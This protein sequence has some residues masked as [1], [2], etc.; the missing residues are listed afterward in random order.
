VSNQRKIPRLLIAGLS[1]G[2]G[3]TIVSLG[4]LQLLRRAGYRVRAFKKGPDYIDPAWL[5]WASGHPARNLDTY[6]MGPSGVRASFQRHAVSD[7]INLIEGNRGLFDGFDVSG[8]HS[9]AVLAKTLDAPILLVID[10]AKMTRTAAALVLGCQK[11]DPHAS[12]RGVVLNNVNGERH[13]KILRSA[14]EAECGIPVVGVL[15]RAANNPLP[16]R[17]L[18]LVPP[19]ECGE[20][21]LIERSLLK[22]VERH[23]DL[24]AV[25]AIAGCAA[26]LEE[27]EGTS[28]ALPDGRGLKIGYLRDSAFSFYYPE[29]LEEL[30]RAGAE[31]VRISALEAPALPD[32][33]H[34]LYIGGGF[35]ETHASE[36]ASNL[37]FL[38]SIRDACASGLPVYAECGGLML[39]ARSLN[40]NG[41]RY[42]M[43]N[44]FPVDVEVFRSPQG[45]GYSQL[46]VD[47]NNPFFPRG[48]KLRGHEFHYSRI[49]SDSSAAVTACSIGRGVGCFAGRDFLI[50]RNAMAGYTHLHA[51]ATPEWAAGM[52]NAAR[53]FAVECEPGRS[54]TIEGTNGP[55]I[56]LR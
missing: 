31:L 30:E 35:P 25:A 18:G 7:G 32:D 33:L 29:N 20:I 13:E 15:P 50:A 6:L 46:H 56:Q 12:I 43:A 48:A 4:L 10:A 52:V 49:V 28:A 3:K 19:E 8:S 41:A 37:C 1:G 11:L 44:V 47:T 5:A 51:T 27:N 17:H 54:T 55:A 2:S 9:S 23:F 53:K 21:D 22:L 34:A 42:P 14:I 38:E 36:L 39:L 45:H 16:E 24:E 26:P 40:W